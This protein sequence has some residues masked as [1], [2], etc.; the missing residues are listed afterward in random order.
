MLTGIAPSHLQRDW[1]ALKQAHVGRLQPTMMPSGLC[2]YGTALN[3]LQATALRVAE[4]H[5]CEPLIAMEAYQD[6]V[7]A[8]FAACWL[9]ARLQTQEAHYVHG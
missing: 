6:V 4:V 2:L 1:T 8:A 7:R 9:A 3:G 5:A